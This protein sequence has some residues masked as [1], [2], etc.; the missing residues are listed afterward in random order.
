MIFEFISYARCAVM[1]EVISLT[2]LTFEPSTKPCCSVPKP[3][4]P[5]V[6]PIASP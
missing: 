1:S 3:A 2:E 5:A 6:P 4:V